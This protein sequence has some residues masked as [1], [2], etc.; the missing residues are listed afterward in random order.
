MLFANINEYNYATESCF[1][2]NIRIRLAS[3][4]RENNCAVV[5]DPVWG[6]GLKLNVQF[7]AMKKLIGTL[8]G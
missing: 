4:I 7:S 3:Y 5:L 8:I 6:E 2:T 1:I